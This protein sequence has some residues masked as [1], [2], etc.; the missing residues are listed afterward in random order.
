MK[1]GLCELRAV[2][3]FVNLSPHAFTFGM[4]EPVYMK[5]GMYIIAPDPISV[6]YIIIPIS[7]CVAVSF[8]GKMYTF[9]NSQ[10]MTGLPQA[11]EIIL[12][13]SPVSA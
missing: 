3:V 6:A 5:P 8:P 10:A 11:V 13:P 4:P 1:L 7:V 12:T 9:F 2:C